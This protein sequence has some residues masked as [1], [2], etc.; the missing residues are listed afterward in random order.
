MQGGSSRN[1]T[2]SVRS[3]IQRFCQTFLDGAFRSTCCHQWLTVAQ[4][5]ANVD[6]AGLGEAW[7]SP[8]SQEQRTAGPQ[9]SRAPAQV[10]KGVAAHCG[11][12]LT[13][14]T[15]PPRFH[16]AA[17]DTEILRE[18]QGG[19]F[20][21]SAYHAR[22]RR[23]R[24][25]PLVAP[26]T[27][28]IGRGTGVRRPPTQEERLFPPELECGPQQLPVH[29]RPPCTSHPM[30]REPPLGGGRHGIPR[31]PLARGKGAHASYQRG[32]QRVERGQYVAD[33]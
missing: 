17:S 5:G 7:S 27:P 9:P 11:A 33:R 31:P 29:N 13:L 23:L 8:G 20:G 16:R 10:R 3:M 25:A 28:A 4:A 32:S 26:R 14:V 12:C 19:D 22:F 24:S 15:L 18:P 30:H 1:V 2:L 6:A 21:C